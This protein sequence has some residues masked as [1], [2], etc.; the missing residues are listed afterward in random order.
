VGATK[1]GPTHRVTTYYVGIALIGIL[2]I[3]LCEN[4]GFFDGI[5]H[6]A[7]DLSF[8]IRGE[9][10]HPDRI[11]IVAID[12]KTLDKLGRWPIRRAHYAKLLDATSRAQVVLFDIVM[13]EPSP[14]D[15]ILAEAI[16]K[17]GKVVLPVYIDRHSKRLI[18]PLPFAVRGVGH[19]HL[20]EEIDGVIRQIFHTIAFKGATLPSATSV[21][22]EVASGKPFSRTPLSAGS[23]PDTSSDRI[24]QMDPVKI[25][26]YGG[27]ETFRHL[28]FTDV[29]EGKYPPEFFRDR[30]VLVGVT[31]VG[32]EAHLLTPFSQKRSRMTGVEVH[33][34]ALSNLIDHGYIEDLDS[35]IQALVCIALA[36]VFFFLFLR[37]G[38]RRATL[39]WVTSLLLVTL[40]VF[41][42]FVVAECWVQPASF[43]FSLT[44][45]F[46]T[47]YT[48]RLDQAA[49]RLDQGYA[50]IVSIPGWKA[51]GAQEA[52][53][54]EGL[55][56]LLSPVGI[57][58][59]IQ[60]VGAI[61]DQLKDAYV[62]ISKDLE[63]GAQIQREL[64]PDSA[65]VI[66]GMEFEWFFYP[67]RF[68]AGD[69]FNYFQ[70]DDAHTG[71]YLADVSGHGVPAAMLAVT[72]SK[73][74]APSESRSSHLYRCVPDG[75]Q[76]EI[77]SPAMVLR[78]LNHFFSSTAR[79]DQ[80]FT[81]VYG[82]I[83]AQGR[84]INLAQAGLP[85]PIL[86]KQSG[87]VTIIGQGG[88][89]V[90]LMDGI[91]YEDEVIA[92][93]PG[94]RV[95]LYSDGIVECF[96]KETEQFSIDRLVTVLQEGRGLPL[97]E[98]LNLVEKRLFD[99]RGDTEFDDDLTMLAIELE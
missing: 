67:S 23:Q 21:G 4:L 10:P 68:V 20:E 15:S 64:L 93:G 85:Q 53:A 42:L 48:L 82:M 65:S 29:T 92:C 88:F 40:S 56:S 94:D 17:S 84:K 25:N 22:W 75:A 70:I 51:K 2:L 99:W 33:A 34:N 8:R 86:L 77:A 55:F 18:Q 58:S 81:I 26:Y 14:D 91:D 38:E 5:N 45:V 47:T 57:N 97:R 59:K 46:L 72:I 36:G 3:F 83:D 41:F 11:I 16:E 24:I 52:T 44:F 95:F 35:W 43:Y 32:I 9:R 78:E 12:E 39:L 61:T 31:A 69:I 73:V 80:Y 66:P 49:R 50:A 1:I 54:R 19:V 62:Q 27:P 79:S 60:L 98:S 13:A 96:N 89:P 30:I 71:F 28:S 87:E 76:H 63:A 7:Y 90:G 74:L 37:L 6:Y